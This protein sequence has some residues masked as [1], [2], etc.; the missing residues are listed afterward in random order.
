M[1]TSF[2]TKY[3]AS[4]LGIIALFLLWEIIALSAGSENIIPS[5]QKAL[6]SVAD[7]IIRPGF[8]NAMLHTIARGLAGFLI[9][10]VLA[11]AIGI[12]AGL[13]PWFFRFINPLLVTIR[14]TPVISFI[15]LAI[16]WLGTNQVPVFIAILT[17]FP[18]ICLNII[19]GIRNVDRDL[20]EMAQIFKVKRSRI[21][22]NI[23]IPSIIPYLMSGI[24]N[25]MGFGW[26]AIIIGEVLSQPEWGIGMEM[27]KAQIYLKVSELIAWTLIAVL[28]SYIF[29]LSLRRLERRLV[30]WK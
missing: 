6:L 15:L 5:P 30:P 26:R 27:Q 11:F 16:I 22:R 1:K 29:E 3:S 28:I 24:S 17:M 12:P 13:S 7:I 10:L 2:I 9:S 14:S 19:E 18:V 25:A 20:I 21:L 8:L 23:Q 4:I